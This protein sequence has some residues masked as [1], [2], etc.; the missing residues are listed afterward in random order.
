[1]RI[2]LNTSLQSRVLSKFMFLLT[3]FTS[4]KCVQHLLAINNIE[5][6]VITAS[7]SLLIPLELF[8]SETPH[9][10]SALYHLHTK[11]FS[12]S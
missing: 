4:P 1:M 12:D 9:S 3:L 11:V 5:F 7:K 8:A 6:L 10:Y 2:V